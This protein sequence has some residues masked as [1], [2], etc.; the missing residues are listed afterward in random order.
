MK[1]ARLEHFHYNADR[2][3]R[4]LA[5]GSDRPDIWNLISR[6]GG[7]SLM[8]TP[9]MESNAEVFMTAGTETTAT[10]LSGLIYL[11]LTHANKMQN[12]IAEI[13]PIFLSNKDITFEALA[14]LP[15]LNAC[16][17]E[18]LRLYPPV[19]SALPRVT[20]N[21]GGMILGQWIPP[22]VSVHPT[23]IRHKPAAE[24]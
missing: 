9:Q 2:L 22:G 20:P 17:E 15:Y 16:I 21:S 8:T 13:R 10:L 4:R 5:K 19:P 24:I 12:L 11:L 7:Q 6:D 14:K 1:Q 3:K 18:A 23:Q